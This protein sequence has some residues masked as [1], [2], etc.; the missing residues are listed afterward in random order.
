MCRSRGGCSARS[1][2]T[3]WWPGAA[4]APSEPRRNI[5]GRASNWFRSENEGQEGSRRVGGDEVYDGGGRAWVVRQQAL[6]DSN[7]YDVVVGRPGRFV[8]VQVKCTVFNTANGMGYIC[9]TC[10]S[11]KQY[12]RGRSTFWRLIWFVR[13]SGTSFRRKKFGASGRFLWVRSA[14]NPGMRNIWRRGI[15]CWGPSSMETFRLVLRNFR[16]RP[17][18][19][20]YGVRALH[21]AAVVFSGN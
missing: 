13:M 1:I 11:H 9:S 18:G 6:G 15:C 3:S 10:S 2:S 4:R 20:A 19:S 14:L 5:S 12:E 8:A 16:V 7:S 17:V 21:R